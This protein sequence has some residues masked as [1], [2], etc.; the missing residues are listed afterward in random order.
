MREF[1]TSNSDADAIRLLTASS[2]RF[3]IALEGEDDRRLVNGLINSTIL[4]YVGSTGKT[5][6]LTAAQ[7][8]ERTGV[9]HVTFVIDRDYDDFSK[10]GHTYPKNVVCR[11]LIS[12]FG[13]SK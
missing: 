8:A 1:L 7:H 10:N 4:L 13:L 6:L 12:L 9:T 11:I 5:G 2:S 3:V